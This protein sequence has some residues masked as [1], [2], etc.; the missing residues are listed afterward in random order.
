[1]DDIIIAVLCAS[2]YQPEDELIAYNE[3][4]TVDEIQTERI[5]ADL[6]AARERG[7]EILKTHVL[8]CSERRVCAIRRRPDSIL[9]DAG[10]MAGTPA[11]RKV[12]LEQKEV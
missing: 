7:R 1:M 4:G 12:W 3:D 6:L 2:R 9:V 8:R 10:F 11:Y 5:H